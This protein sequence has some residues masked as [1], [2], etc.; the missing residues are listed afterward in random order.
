MAPRRAMLVPA[1][2][3]LGIVSVPDGYAGPGGAQSARPGHGAAAQHRAHAAGARSQGRYVTPY[4]TYYPRTA[5]WAAPVAYGS[6]AYYAP[7]Y[8][9]AYSPP[10]AAPALYFVPPISPN[11]P[12]FSFD[13]SPAV[14]PDWGWQRVDLQQLAAE[15]RAKREAGAKP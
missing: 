13:G 10:R 11:A 7:T 12:M 15:V 5:Y 9:P 2:M 1:A 8:A 14:E 3:L 6:T 4:R